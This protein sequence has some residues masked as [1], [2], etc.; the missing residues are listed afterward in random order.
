MFAIAIP[1]ICRSPGT[2]EP[3]LDLEEPQTPY[4]PTPLEL[5]NLFNRN[6]YARQRPD[7]V[8][9]GVDLLGHYLSDG[10]REGV[11]PHPLFDE[12][13][14]QR[15]NSAGSPGLAH[16]ATRGEADGA[17]PNPGFDPDWYAGQAGLTSR[18]GALAHYIRR[19]AAAGLSTH[20]L[21]D[22]ANLTVRA[23]AP[24]WMG[25]ADRLSPARPAEKAIY[26]LPQSPPA[27]WAVVAHI[28][29]PDL[30]EELAAAI[31][32]LPAG[33]ALFITAPQSNPALLREI[34]T[35]LPT[36]EIFPFADHGRD[37][38]PFLGLLDRLVKGGF[39]AVLKL[40]TKRGQTEP[41]AWRYAM[42]EPLVGAARATLASF[43]R[44]PHL[45]M[46]GPRAFY[47][48]G[49]KFIGPNGPALQRLVGEDGEMP[50]QW[51]FFAGTMFWFRPS[52]LAPMLHMEMRF[53]GAN[54]SND[55]LLEHAVERL[56]GLLAT[57]HGG[58]IGLIDLPGEQA[59]DTDL[60][61][62][63]AP[64]PLIDNELADT[65]PG[66]ATRLWAPIR[67]LR[68]RR[69]RRWQ[70]SEE[71]QLGVML[72]GPVGAQNGLGVS[73]RGY[74]EALSNAGL[75]PSVHP[76]TQG[77]ERVRT[78][79][80]PATSDVRQPINLVHLNLDLIATGRLLEIDPLRQFVSDEA[81]N[82][83]IVSWELV[84]VPYEWQATMERF[85]EIWVAS[86]F[87]Q[88]ALSAV[89]RTPVRVV[90]PTLAARPQTQ[91]DRTRLDL[92]ADRFLFCYIADM[93]SIPMRKNPAALLRA[94][95][96]AFAPEDGAACVLKLHYPQQADPAMEEL[97]SLAR[98]RDDIL[99]L[100]RSL[101]GPTMDALFASIDCYVS[102]HRSEGVGLTIVEA[103]Q[104]EKPVIATRFGGVEDFV[105]AETAFFP[106]HRLIQV[107]EGAEPY[108]A[109]AI[110]AD[111][112]EA[113]LGA[114]MRHVFENRAE[115]S[116]KARAGRLHVENLFGAEATATAIAEEVHRIWRSAAAPRV[117][118]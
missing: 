62:R 43:E 30:L 44:D 92:P 39:R 104:A 36:A 45:A 114:L 59:V 116:A 73:A 75:E 56:F 42:I 107:G 51:G 77:F 28:F 87:T 9:K 27:G 81:F 89:T 94:Y 95:I 46:V 20:P 32:R 49:P 21:I 82:V 6:H 91:P 19:G 61:L 37:I 63:R 25:L 106:D 24:S 52:V 96:E 41:D 29:Y 53:D 101:D 109:S 88:R 85:D 3:R 18:A 12:A 60:T 102:P 5:Q 2:A 14:Y 80:T 17:W 103:F 99:I 70:P 79:E 13:Y 84:H 40:H 1:S 15:W 33:G 10:W 16:Y 47:L 100:T 112:L 74:W 105:T 68:V 22:P 57:R 34:R 54:A 66:E 76:W 31:E 26:D 111:P 110:W 55:G 48:S 58:R 86:T 8:G 4:W 117:Q 50:G 113:S 83:A 11:N 90:R 23:G 93:G 115:A 97:V 67:K 64:G 38:A 35:R 7:L 65:L 78:V 118:D 72:I 71:T 98:G 108:P 69:R